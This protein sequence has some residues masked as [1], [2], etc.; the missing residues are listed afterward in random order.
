MHASYV[1]EHLRKD[2]FV[3]VQ[4]SFIEPKAGAWTGEL[5]P[6]VIKDIGI[7]W[8]IL[9][10]SERRQ[11]LKESP[12]FVAEKTR[13][14]LE[15]DLNVILCI[16]ESLESREA[17]TTMKVCISQLEPV[18]KAIDLKLL[19]K[20]VIAY[21][22]V[23]AIGTGKT[24]SPQQAQDTHKD[25]RSWLVDTIGQEE[26][27]KLRIL[28]GGS[29]KGANCREL[30]KEKDIDGFLVGGASLKKEFID[31]IKSAELKAKI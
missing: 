3:A 2:I 17:G 8:T 15:N 9:G 14:A 25:I 22:P 16:G 21:E 27:D 4:N 29:V 23:W 5:T 7:H 24:A 1:V 13:I 11:Y 30:M 19:H 10:H 31:I 6:D 12:D 28:Y 20:M 18:F 26:A